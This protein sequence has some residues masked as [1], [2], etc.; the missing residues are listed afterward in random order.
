[1]GVP[2]PEEMVNDANTCEHITDDY[3]KKIWEYLKRRTRLAYGY[4]EILHFLLRCRCFGGLNKRK[5]SHHGKDGQHL[6]YE[7]GNLKLKR[8]LDIINIIK[9][10]RQ[11]RLMSQ[12]LLTKEQRMLLKFQRKN[13]IE[14]TSS[15][16][17]SD[18][19]SYDTIK[20]LDSKKILVKHQQTLRIQK[21][22][23]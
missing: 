11:L 23:N 5:V 6:L 12:F 18:H 3:I 10:I 17:D 8:E 4:T 19:Y 22:M 15:S 20:L 14:M 16:S 2:P 21:H 7:R 9:Q 13:V 1:M